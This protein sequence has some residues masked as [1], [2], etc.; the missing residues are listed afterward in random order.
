MQ[1]FLSLL[2]WTSY[3][4]YSRNKD[5]SE[6][7]RISS[8]DTTAPERGNISVIPVTPSLII[9]LYFCTSY[10]LNQDKIHRSFPSDKQDY[11]FHAIVKCI[12]F[13]S[14]DSKPFISCSSLILYRSRAELLFVLILVRPTTHYFGWLDNSFCPLGVKQ[15]EIWTKPGILHQKNTWRSISATNT[16]NIWTI[17]FICS[18]CCCLLV[19]PSFWT[20]E[21]AHFPC[22]CFL[23]HGL[24][25]GNHWG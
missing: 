4:V 2:Y 17:Q 5:L 8:K 16:A 9:F 18:F 13:F 1:R 19:C 23:F 22:L 12:H 15:M 24:K 11:C 21:R 7:L 14:W 20:C 6:R 25:D 10:L 3:S